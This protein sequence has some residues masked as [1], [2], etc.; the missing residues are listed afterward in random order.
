[1]EELRVEVD[2]VLCERPNPGGQYWYFLKTNAGIAK[3]IAGWKLQERERVVLR[4]VWT[5]SRGERMFSFSA[6]TVDIPKDEK[7]L[8][9]LACRMTPGFG[10]ATAKIIWDKLG[11]QWREIGVGDV[12]RVNEE[13]VGAL[14][15]TIE[16]LET[17]RQQ[18]EIICWLMAQDAT[19]KI[20][21]KA[22]EE[23][24]QATRSTVED[25][26]FCL[27]GLPYVGFS[28]I[29]TTV[30]IAMGIG[31]DDDR[32]IEAGIIYAMKQLSNGDT[33]ID[34]KAAAES[35]RKLLGVEQGRIVTSM[36]TMM[37][38]GK[39]AAF[40][41]TGRLCLPHDYENELAIWEFATCN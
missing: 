21:R 4:G 12:P 38:S 24:E 37:A 34:W 40:P 7:Q 10:D 5:V 6:A 28:D 14:R 41:K 23:W 35:A 19:E 13:K 22:W 2:R 17:H 25:N 32:R 18:Y 20:A 11:S 9:L 29:D 15:G 16:T 27:T 26:C 36:K 1:M 39:L 31:D 3:G 33:A 30:R 8:L